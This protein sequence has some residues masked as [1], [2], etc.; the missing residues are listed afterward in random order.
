MVTHRGGKTSKEDRNKLGQ[1]LFDVHMLSLYDL[2]K[3]TPPQNGNYLFTKDK[4]ILLDFGSVR[5]F[6][7]FI[8]SCKI[9]SSINKVSIL[10]V[11]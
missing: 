8:S 4:V 11:K 3:F 6:Q 10:I 9:N 7:K 2:I 1:V 5:K